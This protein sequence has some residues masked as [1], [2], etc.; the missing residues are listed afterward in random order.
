M[1]LK[2]C[3]SYSL[4]C[5]RNPECNMGVCIFSSKEY[6]SFKIHQAVPQ[7]QIFSKTCFVDETLANDDRHVGTF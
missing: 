4:S 3:H 1:S 6:E 5:P 2:K 7:N